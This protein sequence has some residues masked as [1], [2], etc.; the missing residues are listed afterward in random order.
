MVAKRLVRLRG[1]MMEMSD[2]S[3]ASAPPPPHTSCC[4]EN[5][6]SAADGSDGANGAL[7]A[8]KVKGDFGQGRVSRT[9][10]T[11]S[12][13]FQQPSL[14][15]R[16]FRIPNP[17]LVS[18]RA[19][20]SRIGCCDC[21][22]S[23]VGR[24]ELVGMSDDT[25]LDARTNIPP[26]YLQLWSPCAGTWTW[27]HQVLFS[28]SIPTT[29]AGYRTACAR[30]TSTLSTL[31]ARPTHHLQRHHNLPQPLARSHRRRIVLAL[32]YRAADASNSATS[33]AA[34]LSH[35]INH[36]SSVLSLA[37]DERRNLLYSGSQEGC[38]HVGTSRRFSQLRAARSYGKRAC[39]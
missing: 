16:I 31:S 27:T 9:R 14:A 29:T 20:F 23:A 26:S 39:T 8:E 37:V 35:T 30:P 1:G 13:C 15:V 21:C 2:K 10:R 24:D 38:I 5:G 22:A 4:D 19:L 6:A 28:A 18:D 33:T 11:F 32:E 17:V 25:I 34:P 36:H 7:R 12:A 3:V